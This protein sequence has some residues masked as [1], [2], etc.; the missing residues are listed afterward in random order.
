MVNRQTKKLRGSAIITA[1]DEVFFT[2]YRKLEESEKPQRTIAACKIGSLSESKNCFII[3]LTFG[4]NTS[5]QY[6]IQ[7]FLKL[8]SNYEI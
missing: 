4:K 8:I 1:Y 3:R 5:R 6:L 7:E 2:P